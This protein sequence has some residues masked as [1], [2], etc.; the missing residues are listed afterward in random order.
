[1]IIEIQKLMD[2]RRVWS[3][4]TFA[5]G[6]F[7]HARA[8]SISYQLQK[9]SLRLTEAT[10]AFLRSPCDQAAMDL[11]GGLA[12][13]LLLLLDCASHLGVSAQ[14]L[15]LYA[16]QKHTLNIEHNRD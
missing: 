11:N 8:L 6:K 15:L 10:E 4:K 14:S 2:S 13:V 12:D 16:N 3:D 7:T 1:M 9:K 5:N